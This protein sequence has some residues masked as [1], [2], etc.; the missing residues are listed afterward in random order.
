MTKLPRANHLISGG[1]QGRGSR[2]P[3]TLR[4]AIAGDSPCH[5]CTAACCKQNGHDYAAL[6]QG[7]EIRRFAAFSTDARIDAGGGRVVIE[8]VL[9]YV[10]GRCQVLGEDERCTIYQDRPAAC[11]AFPCV[12]HFNRDGIGAHG[13]FLLR[14]AP[15]LA[16][17]ESL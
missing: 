1:P 16:M 17:L 3:R 4:L 2:P 11:R 15:V 12:A 7:D 10:N 14:N 5:L 8:K 13:K 9:P 6:L